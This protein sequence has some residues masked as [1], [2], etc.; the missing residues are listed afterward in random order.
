MGTIYA[1]KNTENDKVYIGQTTT[2]LKDRF[3]HH[4]SATKDNK[5][6]KQKLYK[7]MDEI[8]KDKFY[9]EPLLENVPN[10]LLIEK[11]EEYIE[12]YD[13]YRNG[14]NGRAGG[15]GGRSL[16]K[17][18]EE[19]VLNMAKNGINGVAIAN[20]FN[21]NAITIYRIL[22]KNNFKFNNI[23]DNEILLMLNNGMS[24]K[25][26]SK[27]LNVDKKTVQRH[28]WKKGIKERRIYLNHREDFDIDGLKKD[29]YSQMKISDI[30]KKYDISTTTFYRIKT[31][32]KMKRPKKTSR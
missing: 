29:Y 2:K 14:Y 15:K 6:N 19:T 18:E 24:R 9:I 20:H 5:K 28:I 8:G 4:L 32:E 17:K 26:I 25:E 23:D 7:A 12:K 11:E 13:S 22:S 3:G 21:V 16:S 30:C 31:K 1:I 10:K 27:V